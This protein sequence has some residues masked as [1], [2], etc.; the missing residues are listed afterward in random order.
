MHRITLICTDLPDG[1]EA[2][3]AADITAEFRQHRPWQRNVSC[4]WDGHRLVL[5]ADTEHDLNGMALLDEFGDCLV[6]YSGTHGDIVVE[7]VKA[8]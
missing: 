2:E 8:L 6:A 7:S 1:N 5:Q 4:T 3:V